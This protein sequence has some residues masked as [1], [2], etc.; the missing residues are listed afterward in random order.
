MTGGLTPFT[1]APR[2][3][4]ERVA[5]ALADPPDALRRPDGLR[6]LLA[7]TQARVPHLLGLRPD[8]DVAVT[9]LHASEA[10]THEA[11]LRALG[12]LGPGLIVQNGHHGETLVELAA[13]EA[14]PHRALVLADDRPFD[15][16]AVEA[17]LDR[18]RDVAWV[19][20]VAH[21]SHATLRNPIVNA[22]RLCKKRGLV[23]AA[24]CVAAAFAYP[25]EL[26]LAQIDLAI[27]STS[28]ALLAAPGLGLVIGRHGAMDRL[29]AAAGATA[30]ADVLLAEYVAQ[31]RDHAPARPQPVELHAALHAACVHLGEVGI[32]Q[33]M[34]RIRLQMEEL[35]A[36]LEGLGCAAL[37][38]PR[39][40]SWV[41]GN[42]ELPPWITTRELARRL[43]R[44]GFHLDA[45]DERAPVHVSTIGHLTRAD[46]DGFKAALHKL[47][48]RESAARRFAD[49]VGWPLRRAI[50]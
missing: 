15:L 19:Y 46:I 26:E 13:R 37:L 30:D 3:V 32:A 33:H 23:V 4:P 28:H 38:D 7:D 42:F 40:R 39:H 6:R 5:A 1:A 25:I 22:S 31:R 36:H 12:A 41:A 14:V 45:P 24:D 21:E 9:T 2:Q 50:A 18:H 10:A 34:R 43:A 44:E 11:C 49:A 16:R 8:A 47:L 29:V 20:L 35:T 27:A 17:A 48:A